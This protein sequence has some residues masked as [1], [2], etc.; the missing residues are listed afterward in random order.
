MTQLDLPL[1]LFISSASPTFL[2]LSCL[3][4]VFNME[5]C[6]QEP[7]HWPAVYSQTIKTWPLRMCTRAF[8]SACP[9]LFQP[10]FQFDLLS[11]PGS[12][13]SPQRSATA[14]PLIT[15]IDVCFKWWDVSA[16]SASWSP[17]DSHTQVSLK[18]LLAVNVGF[19]SQAFI[20]VNPDGYRE[21]PLLQIKA[22]PLWVAWH[23]S[24]FFFLLLAGA[25]FDLGMDHIIWMN[26]RWVFFKSSI[27]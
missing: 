11:G 6:R 22:Q 1:P 25:A 14:P 19:P 7:V 15:N 26:R 2:F 5:C 8:F 27:L 24:A 3:V 21:S 12:P 23:W 20:A 16:W 4:H 17:L 13:A 18:D 10:W 9:S